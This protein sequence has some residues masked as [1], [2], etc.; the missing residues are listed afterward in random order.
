MDSHKLDVRTRLFALL[1]PEFP[2][3]WVFALYTILISGLY[4]LVP[5]AAQILVNTIATGVLVQPLIVF[6]IVLL[7]ALLFLG[8]LRVLQL[9]IVEL[10]QR[11][12][13]AKTAL[14]IAEHLPKI[15]TQDFSQIYAP[16]LVNR[17][18]D[19]VT[20]QKTFSLI[21][22]E[23]PAAL[24]Q[25]AIGILVL[26]CYNPILLV[27]DLA[28][29][30]IF[31]SIVALGR[32]AISTSLNESS[33]KYRVAYWLEELARCHISFK[34]DRGT[35]FTNS[36]LEQRLLSYLA[37]RTK[38]FAIIL[39]QAS[40]NYLIQSMA[41]VGIL[42][43]GGWLVMNGSLSLGQLV[44]A[45]LIVLI[46]LSA[47][48]KIVQKLESY[49]DM[50]TALEKVALITDF[51][52]ES[53]TGEA[54]RPSPSVA[55]SCKELSFAYSSDR[56]VLNNLDF[57]ISAGARLSLV[58]ASGSGKTTLGYL[59]AGLYSPSS[60]K[61]F[62]NNQ[63]TSAL[64]IN[65]LRSKVALVSGFNEIFDA[66]VEDNITLGRLVSNERLLEIIDLLELDRDL[67]QYPRG[68]KTLLVSEGRNISL[69]QRQRI[70]IARS[71][72]EEPSLLIL[73]EAFSG[74][75][76]LTKLKIIDRIFMK[77]K[78]WTIINISHDAE[79]VSRTKDIM[80]LEHGRI[81]ERGLLYDLAAEPV[82]SFAKLF[83]ELSK[84]LRKEVSR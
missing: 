37:A 11:R 55:L 49:Y 12:I 44:A 63:A 31:L 80:V 30:V 21:L 27:F 73:D 51:Q 20:L 82:S 64:D 75:D 66:T 47:L 34:M 39:R 5:F 23:V 76:E 13:F 78:P 53:Q 61:I 25:I 83:P 81:T 71:I 18:F 7:L 42:A 16:E 15:R 29:V 28:L 54:L 1:A 59:L 72:L 74:M 50:I 68:L 58:G 52:P 9:W 24:L 19:T 17:F 84:T 35:K 56:L 79:L 10:I 36:E 45:E 62:I 67:K 2:D 41:T 57:D 43:I 33:S 22:L 46:I 70:L 4:L 3:L 48:D 6:S 14:R 40:A 26:A 8:L 38:H 69:G 77:D 32:N 60:G 65:T